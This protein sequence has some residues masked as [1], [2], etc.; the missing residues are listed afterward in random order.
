MASSLRAAVGLQFQG[1]RTPATDAEVLR[2]SGA[3]GGELA[4]RAARIRLFRRA[5]L[6]LPQALVEVLARSTRYREVLLEDLRWL[7]GHCALLADAPPRVRSR[8][9]VP[10]RRRARQHLEDLPSEGVRARSRGSSAAAA[11]GYEEG[12]SGG[13]GADDVGIIRAAGAFACE[14]CGRAFHSADARAVHAFA[15]HKALSPISCYMHGPVCP[16]CLKCFW[17]LPR[18][19]HHLGASSKGCLTALRARF[20][21]LSETAARRERDEDNLRVAACPAL[22]RRPATR[23]FGPFPRPP[24]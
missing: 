2:Q 21:P 7:V 11:G 10:P 8:L 23:A 20:A 18:L 1:G 15:A 9:V 16:C 22:R 4:V 14:T 12:W 17:T 13:P 19:L 24:P 3:G 5:V 6:R